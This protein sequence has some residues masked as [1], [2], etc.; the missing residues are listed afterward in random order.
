MQLISFK[1]DDVVKQ[2]IEYLCLHYP[3]MGRK[4]MAQTLGISER[5]LYRYFISLN[6]PIP[7]RK[8]EY[9]IKDVS[10]DEAKR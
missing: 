7:N 10:N 8:R 5:T 1:V 3:Q 4:Q 6:I 2:L 9:V